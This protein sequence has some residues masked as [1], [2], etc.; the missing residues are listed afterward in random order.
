MRISISLP[1]SNTLGLTPYFHYNRGLD[2]VICLRHPRLTFSPFGS[3]Y[4]TSLPMSIISG[5]RV[6]NP[7]SLSQTASVLAL[8]SLFDRLDWSEPRSVTLITLQCRAYAST[9]A[10]VTLNDTGFRRMLAVQPPTILRHTHVPLVTSRVFR[11]AGSGK[12]RVT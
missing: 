8:L 2:L 1:G 9:A 4:S 11:G 3:V 6:Y 12:R 7:R 5:G 10:P